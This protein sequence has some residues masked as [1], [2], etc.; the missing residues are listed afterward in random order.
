MVIKFQVDRTPK[1]HSHGVTYLSE[2]DTMSREN[3]NLLMVVS[4][5]NEHVNHVSMGLSRVHLLVYINRH[6][7][8]CMSQIG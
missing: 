5:L 8:S 1:L 3:N 7:D 4:V 6:V 2:W